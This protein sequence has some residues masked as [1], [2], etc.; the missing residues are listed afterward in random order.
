MESANSSATDAQRQ[1]LL[2]ILHNDPKDFESPQIRSRAR[3][4]G[5]PSFKQGFKHVP[6]ASDPPPRRIATDISLYPGEDKSLSGI[7]TRAFLLGLTL[8]LT[9]LTTAYLL[10][11]YGSTSLWPLPSFLLF[12]SIF[13]FLEFWVT[14]QYNTPQ[15]NV[16]SFLLLSN[17]SAYNI[18]HTG[19]MLECL[20]TYLLPSTSIS[21]FLPP[22]VGTTSYTRTSAVVLG[23]LLVIIGQTTRTL[24]MATAGKSFNHHVQVDKADDHTLITNGVY[25]WLR[26]PSYFGFFWWGIGTQLVLGNR[27]CLVAYA[28][29]LWRFFSGRI[30]SEYYA[31]CY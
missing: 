30:R 4:P 5:I 9:T 29:I 8:G 10:L 3:P 26:H 7:A 6:D 19:A 22:G 24:A 12:L 20:V 21:S 23:I 14:A 25:T 17:G 18:A 13:H 11:T 27:L 15:A 16:G 1:E 2:D 31:G 28:F